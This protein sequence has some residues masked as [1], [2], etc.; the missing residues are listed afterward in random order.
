MKGNRDHHRTAAASDPPSNRLPQEQAQ[1]LAQVA[2][3][4]ELE[5]PHQVAQQADV[6]TDRGDL[7]ESPAQG[8]VGAQGW[9]AWKRQRTDG[10]GHLWG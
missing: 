3:P 5:R 4:S 10:T 8:A 1:P 9:I 6:G 2:A 7:L